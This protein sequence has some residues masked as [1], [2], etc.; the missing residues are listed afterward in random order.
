LLTS[1][2]FGLHTTIDP[3]L[4]LEFQEYYDLLATPEPTPEQAE[5]REELRARLARFSFLGYTRRDQ[6]VLDVV[7]RFLAE[8][9]RKHV[10]AVELPP[11]LRGEIER[12]WKSVGRMEGVQL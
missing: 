12:I 3:A 10:Q 11:E 5:R 1:P 8:E 4:D 6:L 9:R 2:F 7:D